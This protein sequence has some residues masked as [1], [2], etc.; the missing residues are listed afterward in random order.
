MTAALTNRGK[1][2]IAQDGWG[3][4]D[5]HA[6]VIADADTVPAGAYAATLNTVADLL[7]VVGVTE[8]TNATGT[9]Y[10]RVALTGEAV[11]EDDTGNLANLDAADLSYTAV[12]AG[13]WVS[14]AIY[15][16]AGSSATDATR[17]L[18]GVFDLDSALVTNGGDV[19]LT[20]PT[21]GLIGLS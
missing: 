8:A 21:N 18:I 14:V 16:E 6:L 19:S 11:L 20:V 7:A 15:A 4:L 9:G 17:D 5:A 10:A 13:R 12:D 1:L 2:R 3:N